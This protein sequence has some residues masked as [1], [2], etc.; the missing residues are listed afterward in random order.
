MNYCTQY[1]SSDLGVYR[2]PPKPSS[3][4]LER[5]TDD[6]LER[7][8][9][10]LERRTK[11]MER[12]HEELERRSLPKGKNYCP[13]YNYTPKLFKKISHFFRADQILVSLFFK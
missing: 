1:P 5:R 10:V 3:E 6:E 4:D 12:K 8:P 2:D 11:M 9:E 7:R 13:F